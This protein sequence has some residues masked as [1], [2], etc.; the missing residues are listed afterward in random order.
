MVPRRGPEPRVERLALPLPPGRVPLRRP[1][2]GE[3]GARPR[4][5]RVRAARH[6]D[7]RRGPLLGD[8]GALREGR[9][10]RPALGD[11]RHQ[12]RCR[13]RDVLHVLPTAWFRNTWSWDHDAERPSLA[14]DGPPL[15][16]DPPP[17]AGGA[18]ADRVARPEGRGAD[19]PRV[20]QRDEP[21]A[22]RRLATPD[23]AYPKDGINDHVVARRRDGQPDG[24]RD[25]GRRSGTCLDVDA[26]CD[27]DAAPA[28]PARD[29]ARGVGA[30]VLVGDGVHRA[31]STQRTQRGRRVL[32]RAHPRRPR[33]RTRRSCCARRSR[34][35]CGASSST[36]TTSRGGSR[37]TRPSRRR[38]KGATTGRNA[39]WRNFNAFD[40][41][42]MPD[43]WEYPWFA[44][45]D[46]AF[47]CV[48]LARVD[49]AFAKYQ[50][51]LLC[52]EW[53]Q[54]PSGG[55]PAYEWDFGDLNP[56][57]QAWAALEVFAASTVSTDFEFLSR[58]FDKLLVNFTWWVNREDDDGS[59]LFEGGFLGL[60]NIGPIDRSHLPAGYT[61]RQADATGWMA[62]YALAMGVI[63]SL[64][65]RAKVRPTSDLVLKF[66]EHFA[67]VRTALNGLGL[68]NERGRVLLR[69]ARQPR[70]RP[71]RRSRC[72]RWSARS[73][74]S[75]R[76]C[77]TRTCSSAR[78]GA[79]KRCA[80]LRLGA[81]PDDLD[82]PSD[83]G[84]CAASRARG[85]SS[86]A[87]SRSTA[88]RGSSRGC[89][90]SPSSSRRTGCARCRRTTAS[91]PTTVTLDGLRRDDQLRA[92]GVDDPHVRRQL[93]L[94]R[95]GVVPAQLP[96]VRRA[97]AARAAS[98][99]TTSAIEYPTGSTATATYTEVADRPAP[100]ARSRIFLLDERRVDGP[101][102]ATAAKFR[103]DPRWRDNVLFN[104]YFDGDTAKGLGA[105]HQ[106]GWTGPRRRPHP[107]GPRH[108]R[109]TYRGS[110][111]TTCRRGRR[112]P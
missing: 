42:S 96:R 37:A 110:T 75:P 33:A 53:F 69:P 4:G 57:V 6:G 59:N 78:A 20:R 99:A 74:C 112:A 19:R 90:T 94:A 49:P 87:S 104:E 97:R 10:H 16:G 55:L 89:S 60:D 111:R 27:G 2:R 84:D 54:H 105:S 45:W 52:R 50:L 31:S 3:P 25:E 29:V 81:D 35:C 80:E 58:V 108:R 11:R 18:A 36:T 41:M 32:R 106:T 34:G 77:S 15:H 22:P 86:S 79:G 93:E 12:R 44:A 91:T 1:D 30:D 102:S 107:A 82:W 38:P 48:A 21:D 51:I 71:A 7:L 47:H 39:R 66:L 98:T 63:A 24:R 9:P 73:R 92:G 62:Y 83:G 23:A 61:L 17:V 70:R 76:W 85:G 103:D 5:P 13:E 95:S 14:F 40:I 100:P 109:A 43:K 68:W 67:L 88:S 101:A 72:T 64:L 26:G 56:P 65:N 8:R 46:L 28:P